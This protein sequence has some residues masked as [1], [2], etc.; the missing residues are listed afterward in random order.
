MFIS[1]PDRGDST[2]LSEE[3]AE[4]KGIDAIAIKAGVILLDLN[5]FSALNRRCI[6]IIIFVLPILFPG[7]QKS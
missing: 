1:D 4:K 6:L 7:R 3:Q 5:I 2:G